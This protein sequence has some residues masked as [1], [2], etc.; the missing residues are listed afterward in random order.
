MHVRFEYTRETSPTSV[1]VSVAYYIVCGWFTHSLLS[2]HERPLPPVC[3]LAWLITLYVV[4]SHIPCCL[5]ASY[6]VVL[7]QT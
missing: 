4:G 7:C 5:A 1:C 2:T 3:V 6:E